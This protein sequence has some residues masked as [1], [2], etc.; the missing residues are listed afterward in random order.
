MYLRNMHQFTNTYIMYQLA[1]TKYLFVVIERL[2]QIW[3]VFLL[4]LPVT[5]SEV[6]MK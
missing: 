4:R 3:Q 5:D 6:R 1:K 2:Q